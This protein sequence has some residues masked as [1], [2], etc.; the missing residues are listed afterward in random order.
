VNPPRIVV[1]LP[2]YNEAATLAATMAAFHAALPQ[3]EIWVID[4]ASTDGTARIAAETLAA[5]GAA[6]GVLAEPRKGKANAVRRAF[7]DIDADVYLMADADCTYPAERARDLLKPVLEG[8][9]DMVVGDRHTLGHYASENKRPMHGAGN[10]LVQVLVNRLFRAQLADI[11]S[12]Y[13]AFSRRFV[14]SYPIAVEG[15]EFEADV[16]LHALDKRFRIVEVPVEYRDRPAGSVSKLDTWRDGARVLWIILQLF[17]YYRP[18]LFFGSVSAAVML[19]ALAA[20]VPV[21]WDWMRYHYIYHVP[22]AILA[23]SS[24]VVATVLLA[25]GLILDGIAHQQRMRFE[26]TLLRER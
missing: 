16:T 6:G 10:R 21:F 26:L 17:R 15:F 1:V 7:H 12:G 18:M 11:L 4:N 20:S 24:V 23:A 13:R 14:K 9:A 22:L 3:A 2:A 19:F 5:L 8:R 25:V